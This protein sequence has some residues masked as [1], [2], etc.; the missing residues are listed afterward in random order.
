MENC[1]LGEMNE[2]LIKLGVIRRP[3]TVVVDLF[4]FA[5][6]VLSAGAVRWPVH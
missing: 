6:G 3:E 2:R 4:G 1:W 5:A